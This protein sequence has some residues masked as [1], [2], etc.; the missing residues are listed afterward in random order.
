MKEAAGEANM[1]VIT[2]IVIAALAAIAIPM[3]TSTMRN[4]GKKS[5]QQQGGTWNEQTNECDY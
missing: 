1:T 5:C 4:A 2:I 3:V